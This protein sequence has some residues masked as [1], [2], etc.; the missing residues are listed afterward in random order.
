[1]PSLAACCAT[2]GEG[3]WRAELKIFFGCDATESK[4]NL[5]SLLRPHSIR[6]F[7][8]SSICCLT[9]HK[10]YFTGAQVHNCHVK[11][12]GSTSL[13]VRWLRLHAPS[14]GSLGSIPGQGIRSHML[15]LK[16]PRVATPSTA[17]INK[18]TFKKERKKE[19][20]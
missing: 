9:G 1:M 10:P 14:A 2:T 6:G 19:K 17:K 13:V 8:T 12:E 15:Q 20:K 11:N 16:I 4:M 18:Y 5:V 7:R 3:H